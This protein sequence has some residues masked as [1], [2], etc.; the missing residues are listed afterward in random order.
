[1]LLLLNSEGK[2]LFDG[3]GAELLVGTGKIVVFVYFGVV[4]G[5]L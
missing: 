1:M 2:V 4:V 5:R 3:E